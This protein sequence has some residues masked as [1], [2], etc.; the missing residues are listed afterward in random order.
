[1]KSGKKK[2]TYESVFDYPIETDNIFRLF[3]L[4]ITGITIIVGNYIPSFLFETDSSPLA[5]FPLT[6][7]YDVD[8]VFNTPP[9]VFFSNIFL[10]LKP[11]VIQFTYVFLIF[12]ISFYIYKKKPGKIIKGN[13]LI[14]IS[15]EKTIEMLETLRIKAGINDHINYYTN[16][17]IRDFSGQVFGT[18]S[19]IYLKA[20]RGLLKIIYIKNH[21]LYESII[22]HEFSHIKNK[23][24]PKTYFAESVLKIPFLITLAVSTFVMFYAL[25]KSIGAKVFSNE[26]TFLIVIEKAAVYLNLFIQITGLL[27]ILFLLFRMLIRSREYYADLRAASLID[28]TVQIKFFDKPERKFTEKIFIEKLFGYHPTFTLRSDMLKNPIKIFKPSVNISFLNNLIS[29][30]FI[31]VALVFGVSLLLLI[32]T[33]AGYSMLYLLKGVLNE[34]L[35]LYLV[36]FEM[37]MGTLAIAV[38]MLLCGNVLRKTF[39]SQVDKIL[40]TQKHDEGYK[41][42]WPELIR[43][44][45]FASLGVICGY[46][47]MPLYGFNILNIKN[48][49][50]LPFVFIITFTGFFIL[51]SF[52][53]FWMD[54]KINNDNKPDYSVPVLL[55][56][57]EGVTVVMIFLSAILTFQFFA[58]LIIS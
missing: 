57:F 55:R 22:L 46:L 42:I 21:E 12:G 11:I 20:G 2:L 26:L 6:E 17:N 37:I 48:L 43:L 24:I 3:L 49:I 38:F 14:L 36:Y 51:N 39:F 50:S 34:I 25:I 54:H 29:Y 44:S 5:I 4:T 8:K 23:D 18:G 19:N 41:K 53:Y 30:I 33:L 9:D 13:D 40:I 47:L 35:H 28:S 1:M 31:T 10:F 15:D 7:F 52:H 58:A 16:D 32:I 45:A 56:L 27:I